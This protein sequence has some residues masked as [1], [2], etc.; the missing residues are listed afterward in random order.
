MLELFK[1]VST[2]RFASTSPSACIGLSSDLGFCFREKQK[3]K[4]MSP[5]PEKITPEGL[6]IAIGDAIV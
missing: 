3:I 5:D 6:V 4:R 1:S 2:T